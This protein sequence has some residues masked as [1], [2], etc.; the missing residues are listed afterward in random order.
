MEIYYNTRKCLIEIW[1]S[2]SEKN[3][4]ELLESLKPKFKEWKSKKLLPIV[5][6]SGECNLSDKTSELLV[7]N[8][9]RSAERTYQQK[10]QEDIA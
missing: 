1:V 9:K 3:N 7:Y 10:K 2:N 4:P 6:Y 8:R 5:Y